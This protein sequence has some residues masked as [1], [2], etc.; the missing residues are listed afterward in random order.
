MSSDPVIKILIS[1]HKQ[2][3]LP[4]S[5]LFL[6]MHVGAEGKTPLPGMQPD[7]QGENIS[8]RNFTFCEMSG[9]YWAWKNLEADYVGQCHY[10][11][12]F[13]F[14]GQRSK[15]NDH[16]QIESE[17]LCPD[18]LAQYGIADEEAIRSLV[19]SH[20][21]VRAPYWSVRGV[22]TP[23]GPKNTIREHMVAYGLISSESIDELVE[24]CKRVQPGYADELV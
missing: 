9:Q 24:I 1:C 21:L 5:D 10:R 12:F 17:C 11:R 15:A 8:S 23:D 20:D 6:P 22:P 4:K 2:V 14:D 16:G 7:N 13:A 19:C 3:C 18:A